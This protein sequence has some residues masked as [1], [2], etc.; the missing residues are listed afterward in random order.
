MSNISHDEAEKSSAKTLFNCPP[1]PGEKRNLVATENGFM[2]VRKEDLVIGSMLAI[3]G[4]FQKD[5]LVDVTR[6]LRQNH[7][8]TSKQFADVRVIIGT[9]IL[10][11]LRDNHSASGVA[12]ETDSENFRLLECNA[13]LNLADLSVRLVNTRWWSEFE[14]QR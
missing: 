1:P 11:T 12:V 3:Q 4:R 10:R 14:L 8:F 5:N 7:E 6:F 9:H 2:L 13:R